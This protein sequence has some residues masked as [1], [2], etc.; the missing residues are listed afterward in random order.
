MQTTL[1]DFVAFANRNHKLPEIVI[2]TSL[3]VS[4]LILIEYSFVSIPPSFMSN[5]ITQFAL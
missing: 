1:Y 2:K 3:I 4:E 5:A